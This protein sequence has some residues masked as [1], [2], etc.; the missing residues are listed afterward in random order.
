MN[1]TKS[2]VTGIAFSIAFAIT[3]FLASFA[4]TTEAA[5]K[6]KQLVADNACL[7]CHTLTGEKGIAPTFK[8]IFGRKGTLETGATITTDDAYLRESIQNPKAKV[9]KGFAPSMPPMPLSPEDINS[10]IEYLKTV[11]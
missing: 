11:K 9:V 4:G 8:G 2:R 7:S 1:Q 5:P 3:M 10:I 6:G